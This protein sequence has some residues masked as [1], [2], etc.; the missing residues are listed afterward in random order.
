M[1]K[2]VLFVDD[3][4]NFLRSLKRICID[5][6][7]SVLSSMYPFEALDILYDDTEKLIKVVVIDHK[8]PEMLGADLCAKIRKEYPYIV[9]I[10]LTGQADMDAIKKAVNEGEIF[11]FI[12]KPFIVGELKDAISKALDYQ[13]KLEK[14]HKR[15]I[16][17]SEKERILEELE[18]QYPG[19]T[20]VKKDDDGSIVID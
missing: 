11:K 8:M 2:K 1:Q 10:M 20:E 5:E 6:P 13:E 17:S 9:T 14:L 16:S 12:T 4:E 19:I 3:D 15:E 7:Y 18:R